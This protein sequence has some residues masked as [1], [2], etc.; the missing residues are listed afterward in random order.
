[1]C[2]VNDDTYTHQGKMVNERYD[3]REKNKN[4]FTS[5]PNIYSSK[6]PPLIKNVSFN[7]QMK[8]IVLA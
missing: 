6:V 2:L 7:V 8:Y 3:L 4:I 1:M 5:S